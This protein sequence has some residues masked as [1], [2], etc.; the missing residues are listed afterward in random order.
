MARLTFLLLELFVVFDEKA[1]RQRAVAGVV[2]V[3]ETEGVG[4]LVLQGCLRMIGRVGWREEMVPEFVDCVLKPVLHACCQRPL[5]LPPLV[6]T[7]EK[8]KGKEKE[9]VEYYGYVN[10]SCQ[11]MG[12]IALSAIFG[13]I[14][15]RKNSQKYIQQL[16]AACHSIVGPLLGGSTVEKNIQGLVGVI[17]I[18][19]ASSEAGKDVIVKEITAVTAGMTSFPASSPQAKHTMLL[20]T[21]EIIATASSSKDFRVGHIQYQDMEEVI[22]FIRDVERPDVQARGLAILAKL[23]VDNLSAKSLAEREG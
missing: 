23:S 1:Y 9:G 14:R 17:T 11:R 16:T 12:S 7:K 18:S 22:G 20:L 3:M 2:K 21:A 5:A 8:E 6:N 10:L 15:E 4:G 19:M 13:C